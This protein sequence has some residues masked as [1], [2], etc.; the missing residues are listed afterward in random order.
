VIRAAAAGALLAALAQGKPEIPKNDGWVTDR[1]GLLTKEQETQLEARIESLRPHDIAVLIVKNV[2][3][4]TIE[5]LGLETFRDWKLGGRPGGLG[6]LLVVSVEDREIRIEVGRE[7]EGLLTDLI[8]GQIIRN[9][10]TP[11][12]R[13]GR[14]AEGIRAGVD[15]I[16]AVAAREPN[17]VPPPPARS[18]PSRSN[19]AGLL[20]LAFVIVALVLARRRRRSGRRGAIG[21]GWRRSMASP[22]VFLPPMMSGRSFGGG[23]FGGGTFG[24]G[25]GFSGFGG[26]GSAGGGGAT[27]RW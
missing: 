12:F 14:Y 17:A 9:A 16:A 8:S 22:W 21:R 10:I 25:G 19:H 1:A 5:E 11:E 3:G 2:G 7:S 18:K 26:G 20:V 13:R 4:R 15:A 23:S 6:A 24:G 27:G